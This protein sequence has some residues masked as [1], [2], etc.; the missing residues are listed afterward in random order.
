MR[1]VGKM[2][3]D[4]QKNYQEDRRTLIDLIDKVFD[5]S[6]YPG[7][8]ALVVNQSGKHPDYN[9]VYLAF[10]GKHWREISPETLRYHYDDFFLMTSVAYRFYLPAYMR[11]TVLEY[12][13]ADNIPGSIVFSLS[14]HESLGL[15]R[16]WFIETMRD[17]NKEQKKTIIMFLEFLLN[18]HGGD[19]PGDELETVINSYWAKFK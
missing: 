7:D 6:V 8:G 2:L 15:D 12:E 10:K 1:S 9:A 14:F 16:E 19:F 4:N 11:F 5:R 3:T 18:Y 13:E 17:F